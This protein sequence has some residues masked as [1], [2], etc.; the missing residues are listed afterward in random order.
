[1]VDRMDLQI[2]TGVD[3]FAIY[4]TA[5]FISGPYDTYGAASQALETLVNPVVFD[6]KTLC[7]LAQTYAKHNNI[8]LGTVSQY[9]L[10]NYYAICYLMTKKTRGDV[11]TRLRKLAQWLSD[12]WPADLVWPAEIPR[13]APQPVKGKV[14]RKPRPVRKNKST[15]RPCM[16]CQRPFLSQGTHNRLCSACRTASRHDGWV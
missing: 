16:S 3:G 15:Q 12:R 10:N 5:C 4:T 1:M 11:Q 14:T 9:A 2:K 8:S 13:P 7:G 6:I